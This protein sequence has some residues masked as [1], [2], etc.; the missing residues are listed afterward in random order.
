LEYPV[1]HCI[2]ESYHLFHS[3]HTAFNENFRHAFIFEN[4]S[5]TRALESREQLSRSLFSREFFNVN[6][7]KLYKL[8]YS[9]F[10]TENNTLVPA[11]EV[12]DS[13]SIQ[14]SELIIQTIRGAC[15]DMRTKH[16][17]N[18]LVQQRTASIETI[19]CQRK[20]G[21]K[22]IRQLLN[23]E[24]FIDTPHNIQKFANN[25][26]IVIDGVQS[27]FLNSFWTSKFL[28]NAEKTFFFKFHNNT[29]GY[30]NAVAH[31]VRGHSPNCTFCDIDR[32]REAHN[33]TALH[34]FYECHL[35]S[36]VV[37]S[38]FAR[39]TNNNDF[40]FSRREF[41]TT[42]NRR[43]ISNCQNNCLTIVSKLLIKYLWDCRNRAFI[44]TYENCREWFNFKIACIKASSVSFRTMWNNSGLNNELL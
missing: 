26:D 39:L 38:V 11:N 34:L 15:F 10:Y 7:H 41:F 36:P 33:E 31:F 44:P 13:T 9:N 23:F 24:N 42:F 8:K 30:N 22:K 2:S 21:S 37:D 20:K 3:K 40:V 29:L 16:K 17:K 14:F 28:D 19:M 1:L 32:N 18:D 4:P 12:L 5:I 25:L 35:V 27:L 43:E 6:A